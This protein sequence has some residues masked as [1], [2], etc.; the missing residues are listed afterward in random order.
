MKKR[1]QQEDK[2]LAQRPQFHVPPGFSGK[3][4]KLYPGAEKLKERQQA[5]EKARIDREMAECTFQPRVSEL[6]PGSERKEKRPVHTRLFQDHQRK[7]AAIAAKTRKKEEDEMAQCTFKP[8]IS[9]SAMQRATT[10]GSWHDRMYKEAQRRAAKLAAA[11]DKA[12]Q[13]ACPFK[14]KVSMSPSTKT[15]H[16]VAPRYEEL[17][18]EGKAKERTVVKWTPPRSNDDVWSKGLRAPSPPP[19]P[20]RT[21]SPGSTRTPG[22][23]GS[24]SSVR[25]RQRPRT[26]VPISPFGESGSHMAKRVAAKRIAETAR[27]SA[28]AGAGAGA[29]ESG[30]TT[31]EGGRPRSSSVGSGGSKNSRTSGMSKISSMSKISGASRASRSSRGSTLRTGETAA[32][33]T[34]KWSSHLREGD[35]TANMLA[36]RQRRERAEEMKLREAQKM[37]ASAVASPRAVSP[38]RAVAA[39]AGAS[40]RRATDHGA[41]GSV[42]ERLYKAGLARVQQANAATPGHL[43][44]KWSGILRKDKS[45]KGGDASAASGGAADSASAGSGHTTGAAAAVRASVVGSRLHAASTAASQ[46]RHT[47]VGVVAKANS[48]SGKL[49]NAPVASPR[50]AGPAVSAAH[51]R[52]YSAGLRRGQSNTSMVGEPSP[53]PAPP[54]PKII[55]KRAS[56]AAVASA[57]ATTN[58]GAHAAADGRSDDASVGAARV[59]RGSVQDLVA[60]FD[61]QKAA[62]AVAAA[63]PAVAAPGSDPQLPQQPEDDDDDGVAMLV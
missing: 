39:A 8:K 49:R 27:P 4:E 29:G 14:P 53:A 59:K 12:H 50:M 25:R 47:D 23:G 6:P 45:P 52:L 33:H 31:P 10:S 21:L 44:L 48:W 13:E 5:R 18:E 16:S 56:K 22:S 1:E 34:A 38:P 58:G 32:E 19:S 40:K 30:V 26:T 61:K 11:A 41:A 42:H 20:T 28:E 36:A 37:M 17:Y 15:R 54:P 60:R 43:G 9:A 7:Q 51:E 3:K 2:E 63:A 57:G 62:P 46:H 24:R 35:E 55:R